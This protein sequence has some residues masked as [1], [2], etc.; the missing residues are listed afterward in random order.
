MD[1]TTLSFK[2]TFTITLSFF[3]A[4]IPTFYCEKGEERQFAECS[5]PFNCGVGAF[6]NISYPFWG[7][8]R[9]QICGHGGFELICINDSYPIIYINDLGFRILKI[10]QSTWASHVSRLRIARLDTWHGPCSSEIRFVNTTLNY[11][12]FS[13]AQTGPARVSY[14]LT[15]L[16]GCEEPPFDGINSVACEK[17]GTVYYYSNDTSFEGSKAVNVTTCQNVIRVPISGEEGFGGNYKGIEEVLKQGF[18]V[19]YDSNIDSDCEI[20]VRNL[21]GV[22]G[23]DNTT[24]FPKFHCFC[25]GPNGCSLNSG[26]FCVFVFVL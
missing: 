1:L 20:C 11:P 18:E 3:A 26:S 21:H 10:N 7:N 13:F 6:A 9:P 5:R 8:G 25:G 19:E 16:Y 2:L 14:N 23:S 15:F 22:C 24:T 17:V 4:S 12:L